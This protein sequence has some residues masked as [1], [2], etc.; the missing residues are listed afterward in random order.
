M[1]NQE[2]F[3]SYLVVYL[4]VD[5]QSKHPG[6]QLSHLD[7][8]QKQEISQMRC[9]PFLPHQTVTENVVSEAGSLLIPDLLLYSLSA[10]F[11]C[12]FERKR[13]MNEKYNVAVW[14]S[15][16]AVPFPERPCRSVPGPPARTS[17][18]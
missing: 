10:P 16:C 13:R 3:D 14:N 9:P 4:V 18:S 17:P 6:Q 11:V 5:Q 1:I 7:L 8:K 15:A 12:R 2:L